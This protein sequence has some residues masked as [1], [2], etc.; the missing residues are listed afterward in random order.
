MKIIL[1][2]FGALLVI[3]GIIKQIAIDDVSGGGIDMIVGMLLLIY[4]ELV[5]KKL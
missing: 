1:M 3:L 4:S 5:G 2:I